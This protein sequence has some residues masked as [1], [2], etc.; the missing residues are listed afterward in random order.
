MKVLQTNTIASVNLAEISVSQDELEV[1]ETAIKF[2]L[3]KLSEN[4][5]EM[6]FGATKDELEGILED[7]ESAIAKNVRSELEPALT[8]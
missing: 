6:M 1:F 4:E 7:L 5:I 3:K 8:K 2:V